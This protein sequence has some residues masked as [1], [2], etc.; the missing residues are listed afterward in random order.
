MQ[1]YNVK[2]TPLIPLI[3]TLQ[4]GRKRRW[5]L[6]ALAVA[7]L[8]LSVCASAEGTAFPSPKD[9]IPQS[10]LLLDYAEPIIS[11]DEVLNPASSM[12]GAYPVHTYGTYGGLYF[13]MDN[14]RLIF[15]VLDK[16]E[17]TQLIISWDVDGNQV[18]RI[19]L[20]RIICYENGMVRKSENRPDLPAR[21][22]RDLLR[23]PLGEEKKERT[24]DSRPRIY[25]NQFECSEPRQDLASAYAESHQDEMVFPLRE[26]DGFLV[27]AKRTMFPDGRTK[28]VLHQTEIVYRRPD[29]Q[30]ITIPVR[31]NN[32][33]A[34]Y[35]PFVRAYVLVNSTG[36][37]DWENAHTLSI[38]G[39]V[40]SISFPKGLEFSAPILSRRGM[41]WSNGSVLPQSD[42]G[43]YL[44]RGKQLKRISFENIQGGKVSPNGCRLAYT[45][46]RVDLFGQITR[47][48]LKVIDLCKGDK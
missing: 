23:G 14:H 24:F 32:L 11:I 3:R 15:S 21:V 5:N 20:G 1:K 16:D 30:P 31:S 25:G 19:G 6:V 29:K 46:T 2:L 48:T 22:M 40:Q 18:S 4:M 27:T 45:T 33:S 10:D 28:E 12:E 35:Y 34:V 43:L 37:F 36:V 38:D 42:N 9:A 7:G 17:K 13:W 47:P 26:E 41:V 39:D 8:L 44:S